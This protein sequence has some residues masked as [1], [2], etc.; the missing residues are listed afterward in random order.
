MREHIHWQGSVGLWTR[1]YYLGMCGHDFTIL[2]GC[3]HDF[4]DGEKCVGSIIKNPLSALIRV[5]C[6]ISHSFFL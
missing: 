5:N 2:A 1:F 3:G 4:T 6:V